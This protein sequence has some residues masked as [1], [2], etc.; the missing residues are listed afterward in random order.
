MS[1]RRKSEAVEILAYGMHILPST[2]QA[3]ER[4]Y[5]SS[6]YGPPIGALI[7]PRE[8]YRQISEGFP[9]DVAGNVAGKGV[10][11]KL[12]RKLGNVNSITP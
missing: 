2:I 4:K 6:G 9:A 11:E 1:Y 8:K 7:A 12:A 3:P 10:G 5:A